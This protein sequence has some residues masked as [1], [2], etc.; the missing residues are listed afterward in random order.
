MVWPFRKKEEKTRQ[1]SEL[2]VLP[3][4]PELPP[5]PENFETEKLAPFKPIRP[6]SQPVSLPSFPSNQFPSSQIGEKITQEAVKQAIHAPPAARPKKP[7]NMQFTQKEKPKTIE[8]KSSR[9]KPFAVEETSSALSAPSVRAEPIFVRIDKYERALGDIQDI[10]KKIIEIESLLRDIN[11]IREKEDADLNKWE[12]EI[13]EAKNK[14][15]DI[16]KA[17]F[18]KLEK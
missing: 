16:D 5:L 8:I 11:E 6:E 7:I 2:P 15:E 3:E 17:I 9:F 14:L 13:H 12:A 18:N 10:K 4:L 1:I